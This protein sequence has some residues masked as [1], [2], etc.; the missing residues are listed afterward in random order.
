METRSAKG[1]S[2]IEVMFS[3]G[4][5]TVGVLGAA[6]VMAAGIQNLASSPADVIVTQKAAQAIEAVFAARDSHRLNWNQ[7]R[8]AAG[9][10]GNDGGVFLDDPQK[11]YLAGPDGLVNTGDD[12]DEI[13]SVT[14]PGMDRTLGTSDDAV[15]ELLQYTRQITIRD[16][17]GESGNLRT[18]TVTLKYQSGTTERTYTLHTLISAY[19]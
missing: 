14:L 5:L 18:V 6:A 4:I 19:S 2:L 11:L 7:I 1:F 17:P 15:V 16:V 13:E 8:N 9:Y 3:L 10:S 12:T